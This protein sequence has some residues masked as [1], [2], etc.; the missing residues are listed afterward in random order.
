MG[1]FPVIRIELERAKHTLMVA[2]AEHMAT[3]DKDIRVAVEAT[4]TPETCSESCKI[5]CASPFRRPSRIK[6]R[7]SFATA[8]AAPH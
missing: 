4:I 1:E 3:M 7:T 2:I 8:R 5:K 6:L